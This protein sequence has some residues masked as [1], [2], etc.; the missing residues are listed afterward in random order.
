[1]QKHT[2]KEEVQAC[3]RG[4]QHGGSGWVVLQLELKQRVEY[5][6]GQVGFSWNRGVFPGNRMKPSFFLRWSW[7]CDGIKGYYF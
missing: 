2:L 6:L 3:L 1:M 7:S 4:E 5:S